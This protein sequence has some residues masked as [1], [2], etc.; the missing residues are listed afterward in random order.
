MKHLYGVFALLILTKAALAECDCLIFPFKPDPPCFKECASK[1]LAQASTKELTTILGLDKPL[2][3]KIVALRDLY[4]K[5][6]FDLYETKLASR[7][8][9]RV[10]SALRN[11]TAEQAYA[12]AGRA[13]TEHLRGTVV[14][15]DHSDKTFTIVEKGEKS[16]TFQVTGKTVITKGAL[17][18]T[19]GDIRENLEVRGSYW[20][21]PDGTLE[22]K[23]VEIGPVKRKN[24]T[25]SPSPMPSPKA[26]SK[27]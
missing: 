24:T 8:A 14:A 20:K 16:R 3:Q 18:A 4:G 13:E 17:H 19:M 21:N 7:E 12:L 26:E 25:A 22:A 6:S 23:M 11:M 10:E 2:A 5:G 27:Q 1:I 15:V 9:S